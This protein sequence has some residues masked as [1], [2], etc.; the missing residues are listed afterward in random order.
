M[1]VRKQ[2]GIREQLLDLLAGGD[3]HWG[4]HEVSSLTDEGVS[5]Q[6]DHLSTSLAKPPIKISKA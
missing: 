3:H 2:G 5:Q 1:M 6:L 4:E